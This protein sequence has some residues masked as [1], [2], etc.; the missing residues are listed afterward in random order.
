MPTLIIVIVHTVDLSVRVGCLSVL[1][2]VPVQ[3]GK[4]REQL[5]HTLPVVV[6]V[7]HLT[8]EQV[9]RL[10]AIQLFLWEQMGV[11]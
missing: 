11:G 9:Q 3:V 10:Q 2:V 1:H 6:Q 8:V 4:L 7:G 5:E